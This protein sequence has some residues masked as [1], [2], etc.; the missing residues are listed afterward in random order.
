MGS[1]SQNIRDQISDLLR[2]HR[3]CL[4]IPII[5]NHSN[6]PCGKSANQR[7]V[8]LS[9]WRGYL[10]INKQPVRMESTFSYLE[11]CSINIHSLTQVVLET[12]RQTLSFSVLHVEDLEAMVGHMTASLK[13]IFPDSSPG[14]LLKTITPDLQQRLITFTGA[15]EEQLNNQPASCGGFSD[16]YAALC[17]FNEMQSREEI[18]W[19]VDNIYYMHNWRQFKL[20]DFSH[21]DSRDLALAVAALSFNQWFTKISCRELKL[22]VDVQQQLTFL[23]SR[24]PSLEELLLEDCGLKLDFAIKMAAAMRE[25]TSSA[26]QA[27]NLSGNSIEDKGV[28]ALSQELGNL[29][30][31]LKYLSL[32]RVSMT[33]RGLGCLSQVLSSSH[34]LSASLTHLDLSGNPS[35]LVTEEAMFLFKFLSSTNSISHLDLSDT[36]CPLDTLFVSLSAGCCYKL[37]HLN[38]ARNPFSHRKVREVTKSIREF[39]TKSC[40]L[41]YVGLSGTKLPPQGLRLLL[42]GLATNTHLFGLELDLSSCELRSAGAQVIQEHI[43]EATAIKSLDISDNGFEND[44][45]TLVLTVGRC[46]SLRHLALGRN[47]AMKS[48]ALTDVLH[49]IAQLIQDEECPLQSLSVCDSRLKTGMHILFSALGG[50]SALAELDISGN[51]IGDIG[52]K[53]LAKALMNNTRLRSLTWDR[54]NVTARGFQDVADALERNFTLQQLS[55]P[56]ADITQHYRSNPERTK[57]ALHK[58]QQCLDRNNQRVSD[59]AELHQVL[60][61]QQSEKVLQS[62]CRQLEDSLQHL[63]HC[64]THEVQNDILTAHEVLHNAREASKLLPF[65][66]EAGRTHTSDGHLVNCILADTTTALTNEFTRNIQEM[67]QDL[68]RCAEAVCPRVVQR[69]SVC[70][71]LSECVSKKSK[72][73]QTFLRSTLVENTGKIIINRLC[74]LKQTLSVSLAETIIEQVHED[75]TMAQDKVDC[76]IKENACNAPKISNPELCAGNSNFPTD[77]YSPAFW[78]NS[79]NSKSLRPAPS[80]KSLLDADWEQHTRERIAERERGGGAGEE[81]GA[82]GRCGFHQLLSATTLSVTVSRPSPSTSYSLSPSSLNWR[83]RERRWRKGEVGVVDASA[84][85][86]QVRGSSF[87]P[88]PSQPLLHSIA[89]QTPEEETTSHGSLY[90]QEAPFRGCGSSPGPLPSSRSPASLMEPLPTQGQTLRHYTASRPRPH[91]THTQPPSSRLQD[92]VSKVGK[93]TSEGMGRVDEGVEEF[94]TKKIIPDYALKAQRGESNPAQASPLES[95]STPSFSTHFSSSSENITPSSMISVTSYSDTST[96]TPFKSTYAQLLSISSTPSAPFPVTT[97]TLPTKNIKKKFGDFFAFKRARGSRASKGGGADGGEG[98]GAKV[99][100]TSIA[101]LIRPLREARERE[102]DKEREKETGARSFKDANISN[103]ATTEGIVAIGH[104]LA[105]DVR[106]TLPPAVTSTTTTASNEDTPSY[107][108]ITT[109]PDATTTVLSTLGEAVVVLP[110]LSPSS[111]VT[112]P[113]TDQEISSGLRKER[114]LA[115]SPHEERQL[116]LTKRSLR[117]GKSQ[118]LILLTGLEPE[119]KDNPHSKKHVSESTPSFEQRLSVMLHRMGEAKTPPAEPKTGQSK[120]EELRKANSEGAILEKPQPPPSYMKPRTMSTSSDPRNPM[121]ALDLIRPDPPILLKPALPVRPLGPLP[122]KPARL[123]LPTPAASG[124]VGLHPSSAPPSSS[125]KERIHVR[126]D[127]NDGWPEETTIQ[128]GSQDPS[129]A[130]SAPF[131]GKVLLPPVLSRRRSPSPQDRSEKAKSL[132]D[133]SL[134]K[135]CQHMKPVP[136]RRPASIHEDALA[137]TQELKAV[138]QSSP[139]RFRNRGELTPCTEDPSTASDKNRA[140]EGKLIAKEQKEELKAVKGKKSCCET[141]DETRHPIPG[142]E[143]AAGSGFSSSTAQAQQEPSPTQLFSPAAALDKS[144]STLER[145]IALT[146]NLEKP[147]VSPTCQKKSP[148]TAA[149]LAQMLEIV[150]VSPTPQKKTPGTISTASESPENPQKSHPFHKKKGPSTVPAMAELRNRTQEKDGAV[151]K[152]HTTKA[153]QRTVSSLFE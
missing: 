103:E 14:K 25:H 148:S 60:K 150:L 93:E 123:P 97:N 84:A 45:V 147:P 94:F 29:A 105:G 146:Q 107:T 53:M 13:R 129:S 58:I 128:N 125:S 67:A 38:L 138:L 72:L 17:D 112:P 61:T 85:I 28:I 145:P 118:S 139:I 133:E 2:P 86:S 120:D 95:R 136:Q 18:Q 96:K 81:G 69:S 46:H 80:V 122:P 127:T 8:V 30:E 143:Q 140:Q 50:H 39:F 12:D 56:L 42:Q 106:E 40:E 23:L 142:L 47:F 36:N 11:I 27:I 19:D 153:D 134:P 119:D 149:A 151:T 41:K 33:S 101:D 132:T 70:E 111:L 37:L 126:R 102:K 100:R 83:W 137:M 59:R 55:L 141:K 34:L 65:L 73:T 79:F 44:M 87:I 52:A 10:L 1:V 121:T 104:H 57:E 9:L 117:E 92:P 24:S 49:R 51:N 88:P 75:L 16:T 99:K 114:K 22:T 20:Q 21:L 4:V 35:S 77:D 64:S 68:M 66:F 78:R 71:C 63:S 90:R 76:L 26:L 15:I 43:S 7:F 32:S 135:P 144:L 89:A 98:E 48:R 108:I 82:E 130:A 131:T 152:Q 74:E 31:G 3:V 109:S 54:N 115:G 62:M 6:Q 124:V 5:L 91:R 113:L 110:D 116:K